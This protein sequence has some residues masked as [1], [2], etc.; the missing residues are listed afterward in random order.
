MRATL[1]NR[2]A[3]PAS[4]VIAA[5]AASLLALAAL[6]GCSIGVERDG[7][8]GTEQTDAG[9][10]DAGETDAGGTDAGGATATATD[11]TDADP[12]AA[13]ASGSGSASLPL[14][15]DYEDA[16][17]VTLTCGVDPIEIDNTADTIDLVGDCAEVTVSGTGAIVLAEKI[18][19]LTV[20]G[21]ANT[22][23]VGDVA[24]VALDGTGN[25]VLWESDTPS[26]TDVGTGNTSR[27][28]R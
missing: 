9:G 23:F 21:V 6:T 3:S 17:N 26:I 5:S 20:N 15:A 14:R 4:R 25:T 18:G 8:P 27:K 7:A 16:A 19:I 12:D 11:E 28:A 2:H 22:V 24:T 10:T 13:T 1:T